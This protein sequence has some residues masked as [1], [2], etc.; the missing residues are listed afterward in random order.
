ME[1]VSL[2][3]SKEKAGTNFKSEDDWFFEDNLNEEKIALK[4]TIF[5]GLF[6]ETSHSLYEKRSN[7]FISKYSLIIVNNVEIHK[8]E[9]QKRIN[10]CIFA[11]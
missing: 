7:L 8:Y 9:L 4:Y 10:I 2:F 1:P 5:I 6:E 3:S 11:F